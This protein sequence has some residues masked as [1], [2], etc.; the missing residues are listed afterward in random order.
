[1][2][3]CPRTPGWRNGGSPFFSHRAMCSTKGRMRSC[4]PQKRQTLP[5]FTTVRSLSPSFTIAAYLP[6]E[7]SYPRRSTTMS[8]RTSAPSETARFAITPVLHAYPQSPARRAEKQLRDEANAAR[9]GLGIPSQICQEPHRGR[10]APRT[11]PSHTP[12]AEPVVARRLSC[13]RGCGVGSVG[14][15][16]VLRHNC[17]QNALSVMQGLIKR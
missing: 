10:T 13:Q 9:P 8:L 14:S 17:Q 15:C 1:M 2:G 3:H 5:V 4:A 6:I 11:A 12:P 7:W 16:V